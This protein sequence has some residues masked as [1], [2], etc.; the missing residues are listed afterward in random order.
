MIKN[1][2]KIIQKAKNENYYDG[3]SGFT[4]IEM[5]IY[6]SLF[7]ILMT[8]VFSFTLSSFYTGVK[9]DAFSVT[10]YKSLIKNYHVK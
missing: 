2:I 4:L 7:S 10:N 5:I 6:T 1:M 3:C 8:G 9:K